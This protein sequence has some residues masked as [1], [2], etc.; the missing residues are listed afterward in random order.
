[1][2]GGQLDMSLTPRGRQEAGA[3]AR[4]L[5]GVRLDRI[6]SSPMNR[7]LETA[8]AV[9]T[10]RPV[11]VD[12]RLREFDYG[13]WE[14]LT[15][16]ETEAR[17]PELR[18]SWDADPAATTAPGGE[19]GA[20][21]AARAREFLTE[22]VA[23]ELGS[24]SEAEDERRVLVVAHGTFNRI[25]LCV[26][27]GVPVRERVPDEV[28]RAADE[29]ELVDM[30]PHAL[31]QRMRHGNGYPVERATRALDRFFTEPNLTALRDLSLRFVA[32]KV[33][34]QLEDI[35][36]ER[37]LHVGPVTERV[38]AL[39]DESV[40]CRRALRRAATIAS[41][42]HAPLLAL[43]IETPGVGLSRD[44]QQNIKSNLDYATDL[45]AEII[46]GEASDLARGLEEVVRE[47]RVTH[48]VLV[49]RPH[50]GLH[51]GRASLADRLLD[52]VPGLEVH[53]VGEPAPAARQH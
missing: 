52:A 28:V 6:V 44:R 19:S 46:R 16:E 39:V 42:L 38:M 14:G 26:A 34:D 17:D 53:L 50:R 31:R 33:E 3:L 13:R 11:E 43:A 29:I 2:L 25:L 51:V 41:A 23:H 4:R 9:A 48:L 5:A 27:L 49:H 18:A 10:G 35:V 15:A 22:I 24:E 47:R 7:A 36:S 12:D 20:T 45:G 37:G 32:G 21:V 8:Q 40:E 1:M 30:S